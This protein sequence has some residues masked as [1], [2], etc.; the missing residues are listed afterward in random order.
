MSEIL[1]ALEIRNLIYK[2]YPKNISSNSLEYEKSQENR[3]LLHAVQASRSDSRW[4][5]FINETESKINQQFIDRS[6]YAISTP[7]LKSELAYNTGKHSYLVSFYCSVI[8]DLYGFKI[9]NIFIDHE[10]RKRRIDDFSEGELQNYLKELKIKSEKHESN[11]PVM[12]NQYPEELLTIILSLVATQKQIF[13]YNL[14]PVELANTVLPDVS[15]NLK[16]LG[17]ASYFDCIFCDH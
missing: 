11:N 7:C 3:R 1:S 9:K 15:T 6:T 14:L 2:Y 16:E 17:K 12:I 4:L 10:V 5:D 8:A 13:G